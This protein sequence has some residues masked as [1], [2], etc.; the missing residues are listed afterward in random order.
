LISYQNNYRLPNANVAR[1]TLG[2]N[3]QNDN[4]AGRSHISQNAISFSFNYFRKESLHFFAP[5]LYTRFKGGD[6]SM[7]SSPRKLESARVNG[8]KSRGPNTQHGRLGVALNAVTHGL[9]ARTVVLQNE[10]PDEYE[11]ELRTYFDHFF[12]H[13][14][15]ET[16]LV[17]QLAA[18]AWRLTRYAAV[19]SGM[20]DQKMDAQADWVAEKHGN[21]PE[22]QR[23]AI[24]FD[25]CSGTNSAL[26]L[27]NRYEA[28]LHH[29]Y[30]RILKSLLQMQAARQSIEAKLQNK[31]NPISGQSPTEEFT[32]GTQ[33][34]PAERETR[35]ERPETIISVA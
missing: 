24:A 12:P 8:A 1:G 30:Q 2:Q 27:L 18:V 22:N 9:T 17:H 32:P 33:S 14:K 26:A 21:L 13:G 5:S 28:R 25:A 34:A 23:L 6:T 29:E 20:L 3:Q 10:S 4:L 7:P 11:I 19:E 31:P 15:P 16:D 35:N